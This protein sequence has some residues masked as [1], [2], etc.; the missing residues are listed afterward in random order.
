MARMLCEKGVFSMVFFVS[1]RVVS[2][3]EIELNGFGADEFINQFNR[4]ATHLSIE[5]AQ[6]EK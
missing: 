6:N 1:L 2:E 3:T 5:F 4:T